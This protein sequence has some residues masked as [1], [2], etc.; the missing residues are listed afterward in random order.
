MPG[1]AKEA[2]GHPFFDGVKAAPI[3]PAARRG[4]DWDISGDAA[5]IAAL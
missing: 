2:L 4:N 5:L 3:R 1:Q